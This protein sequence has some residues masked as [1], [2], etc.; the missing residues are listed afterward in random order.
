[1]KTTSNRTEALYLRLI[2]LIALPL[3]GNALVRSANAQSPVPPPDGLVSWWDGDAISGTTA[4]DIWDGIDGVMVGGV[5]LVPGMVGQAFSFDGV[6]DYVDLP[7]MILSGPFTIEMWWSTQSH[8]RHTLIGW[9]NHLD[10][11]YLQ[12]RNNIRYKYRFGGQETSV[13]LDYVSDG[14]LYH[15]ALT[16]DSDNFVRLYHNGNLQD[17]I[18]INAADFRISNI[19]RND[20]DWNIMNGLIDEVKVLNRALLG[21]EIR[22]I[23]NAGSA[24]TSKLT[25]E[26]MVTLITI[27]V[28]DLNL[29][30]GI[31]DSLLANLDNALKKLEDGNLDNDTAAINNLQAFINQVEA[32]RGKNI[33]EA[34]ADDL[35]ATAQG[36]INMLR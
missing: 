33:P 5:G 15:V 34:D 17:T 19:A 28:M 26:E 11:D 14:T 7:E 36:I 12:F 4:F 18:S 20:D 25:P 13:Y 35:I 9:G 22:A 30:R 31:S 16:R 10:R 2:L 32:Q 3:I 24:G 8:R 6:D 23:Y 21:P 1:M 29:Q 27:E